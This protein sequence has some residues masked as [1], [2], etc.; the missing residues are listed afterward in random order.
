MDTLRMGIGLE[1]HSAAAEYC[2]LENLL[3]AVLVFVVHYQGEND[4]VIFV[5]FSS[6]AY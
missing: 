3:K 6:L 4:G 2:L 1:R 5:L